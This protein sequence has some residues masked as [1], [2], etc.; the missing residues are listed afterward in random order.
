MAAVVEALFVCAEDRSVELDWIVL[1]GG[2]GGSAVLR[3]DRS[4]Q[5]VD[6]GRVAV[7]AEG[8]VGMPPSAGTADGEMAM[9]GSS[10]TVGCRSWGLNWDARVRSCFS[11]S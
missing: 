4:G 1:R 3:R 5:S 11:A 10:Y 7:G 6:T 2:V 8:V 9:D